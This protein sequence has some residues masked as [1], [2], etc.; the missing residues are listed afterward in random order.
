MEKSID[1]LTGEKEKVGNFTVSGHLAK[2]EPL[3]GGFGDWRS[4]WRF[5][6]SK[7][8]KKIFYLKC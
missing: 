2:V 6:F 1:L 5:G 4:A 8:V 7:Q 3:G